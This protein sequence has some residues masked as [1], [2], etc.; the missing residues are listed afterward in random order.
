[1]T[2]EC[3]DSPPDFADDMLWLEPS[4]ARVEDKVVLEVIIPLRK[5]KLGRVATRQFC[6]QHL[7]PDSRLVGLYHSV[8][9]RY[10]AASGS[11]SS[12]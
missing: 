11:V 12:A 8:N 2:Q 6:H 5:E 7:G 4:E 9:N 1:M 3:R 10:I